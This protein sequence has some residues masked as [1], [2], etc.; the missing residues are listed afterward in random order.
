MKLRPKLRKL[1][2]VLERL[3]ETESRPEYVVL[4]NVRRPDRVVV[5][6]REEPDPTPPEPEEPA[7][8]TEDA[9]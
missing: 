7:A 9:G 1:R 4:D 2:R 3:D 8:A 5:R 6:L